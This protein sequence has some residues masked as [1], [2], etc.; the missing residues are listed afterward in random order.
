[1]WHKNRMF[2]L[3]YLSNKMNMKFCLKKLTWVMLY[4]ICGGMLICANIDAI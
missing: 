4:G 2:V 1:M 3:F